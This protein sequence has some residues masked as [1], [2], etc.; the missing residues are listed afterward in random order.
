MEEKEVNQQINQVL[1]M[2]CTMHA[3]ITMYHNEQLSRSV[4]RI[5]TQT[6]QIP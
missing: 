3:M 2:Q 1:L 6:M 4:D 5:D